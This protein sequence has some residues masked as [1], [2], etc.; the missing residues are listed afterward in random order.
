MGVQTWMLDNIWILHWL[1]YALLVLAG[2]NLKGVFDRFRSG[3]REGLWL[4]L[5]ISAIGI[6]I[7]IRGA[8]AT[9]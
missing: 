2:A 5:F 4:M 6:W 8:S 7:G 3:D 1:G 9:P